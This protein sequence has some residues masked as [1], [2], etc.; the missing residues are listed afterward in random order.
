MKRILVLVASFLL[1]ASLVV[2]GA[3]AKEKEAAQP[4]EKVTITFAAWEHQ[5]AVD[6]IE[7]VV[8]KILQKDN[9]HI[10]FEYMRVPKDYDTKVSTM[11]A[12]GTPPDLLF[13][14]WNKTVMWTD[15]GALLPLDDLYN[16]DKNR[17]FNLEDM[18]PALVKTYSYKGKLM[19]VPDLAF[20]WLF[21]FN[22]DEFDTAGIGYPDDDWTWQDQFMIAAKKMTRDVDG[23]KKTD[24]Y[25]YTMGYGFNRLH[26]FVLGNGGNYVST[27]GKTAIVD[28]P[29]A[30]EALQFIAD[31]IHKHGVLP[32]PEQ[33]AGQNRQMFFSAGRAAMFYSGYFYF[34]RVKDTTKA[35]WGV[36]PLPKGRAGR[37]QFHEGEGVGIVK[38]SKHHQDAWEVAKLFAHPEYIK[39]L[40]KMQYSFGPLK[41][42]STPGSDLNNY[43]YSVQDVLTKEEAKT[44]LEAMNN[45]TYMPQFAQAGKVQRALSEQI[46]SKIV[47]G[48]VS[49]KEATAAAVEELNALLQGE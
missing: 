17:P 5:E 35:R 18:V 47:S 11:I 39:A 29:E 16:N 1:F 44:L 40:V 12:G 33:R 20:P 25:G 10:T 15:N 23:D 31:L 28:R 22:K 24:F 27:D 19:A 32:T 26:N 38:S 49:M 9:P 46:F 6:V 3:G 21:Y 41:E 48:D 4:K 30:Y 34:Q 36:G 37:P 13:V 14:W 8:N 43:Y 45:Q 7:E 2:S 42:I